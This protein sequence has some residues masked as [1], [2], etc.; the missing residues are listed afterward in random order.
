MEHMNG[1]SR[2]RTDAEMK[3][4][5]VDEYKHKARR[6]ANEK[7]QVGLCCTVVG[8]HGRSLHLIALSRALCG[9]RH[10]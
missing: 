5:P 7:P 2:S 6:K 8:L 3:A 4:V 10:A 1:P 9:T